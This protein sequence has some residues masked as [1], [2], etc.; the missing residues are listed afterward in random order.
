MAVNEIQKVVSDER[1]FANE[2]RGL[3]KEEKAQT[4]AYALGL[5]AG[6]M[7]ATTQKQAS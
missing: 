3:S 7:L 2:L 5:Q 1:E 6:K 4:L